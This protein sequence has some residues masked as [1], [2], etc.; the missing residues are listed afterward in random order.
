MPYQ[1]QHDDVALMAA[2]KSGER[3]DV[4]ADAPAELRQ[5]IFDSWRQ[6]A[7]MRA[8]AEQCA[9]RLGESLSLRRSAVKK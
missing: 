4:P 9:A 2:V 5:V 8:T 3:E 1:E 6:D 7:A